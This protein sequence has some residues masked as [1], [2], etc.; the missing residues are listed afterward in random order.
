MVIIE[1]WYPAFF[2]VEGQWGHVDYQHTICFKAN[3]TCLIQMSLIGCAIL[4]TTHNCQMFICTRSWIVTL[5]VAFKASLHL[6]LLQ[7]D[8][9]FYKSTTIAFSQHYSNFLA[10]DTFLAT[11]E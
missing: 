7:Q 10:D 11:V 5:A 1:S 9:R 8:N 4:W 2:S 6:F 3:S